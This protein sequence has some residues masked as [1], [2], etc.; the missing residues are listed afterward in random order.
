LQR[1]SARK[2]LA[3]LTIAA[4]EALHRIA[5]TSRTCWH[6]TSGRKHTSPALT[7]VECGKPLAAALHDRP[8]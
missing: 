3:E 7:D 1:R 5:T 4:E 8:P 6:F 2:F